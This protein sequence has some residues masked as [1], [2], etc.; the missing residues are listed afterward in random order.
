MVPLMIN[1]YANQYIVTF[2]FWGA[3]NSYSFDANKIIQTSK[4]SFF[5]D[6]YLIITHPK[7]KHIYEL[8]ATDRGQNHIYDEATAGPK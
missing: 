8:V 5:S 4:T 2:F 1:D 6:Q 3:S 7:A